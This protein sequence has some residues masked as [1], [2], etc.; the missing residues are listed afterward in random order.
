MKIFICGPDELTDL[1]L[2][3]QAISAS[4]VEASEL[5]TV[6]ENAVQHR[7]L[8]WSKSNGLKQ[9]TCPS[10]ATAL[11]RLRKNGAVIAILSPEC[12]KTIELV[13]AAER[14]RVPV[15]VFRELYRRNPRM[16]CRLAPI[17]R[18]DVWIRGMEA[19][20]HQFFTELWEL[21]QRHQV[22]VG[23]SP[24]ECGDWLL[25][26]ENAE[27]VG[28]EVDQEACRVRNRGSLRNRRVRIQEPG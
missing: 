2:V 25:R 17:S 10:V 14:A 6:G 23:P 18:P 15:F 5:F 24:D 22:T 12:E 9:T 7:A 21:C 13:D 26:F 20:H 1:E 8:E 11:E 27:Y 3:E 16:N 28:L 4:G 19:E